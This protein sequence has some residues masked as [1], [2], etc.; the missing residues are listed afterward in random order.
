M[1]HRI[2]IAV[3]VLTAL[4]LSSCSLYG[5]TDVAVSFLGAFTPS[6]M[7]NGFHQNS[8]N[9]AGGMIELRHFVTP[10]I[11]YEET[12]S[13]IRSNQTYVPLVVCQPNA[14][15]AYCSTPAPVSNN[16]H[17]ITEDFVYAFKMARLKP[18]L[19][20]GAGIRADVPTGYSPLV[21][22]CLTS[23]TP[24]QTQVTDT[25]TKDSVQPVYVY[26]AGVDWQIGRHFGWRL[27]Y[28][29]NLYFKP[30][31][32]ASS[33]ETSGFTHTAEPMIGAFFRF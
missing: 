12:Y 31:L 15:V 21:I 23:T 17:E 14:N 10:H 3:C 22:T 6:A 19:L 5:Q 9:Q 26:G 27:Q 30:N 1:R 28:R 7:G 13:F 25:V 32:I 8:A 11:G 18:F 2:S 29:G 16:T 24:C 33:D 20:A 4:L